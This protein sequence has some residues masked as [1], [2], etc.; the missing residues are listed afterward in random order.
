LVYLLLL[1]ALFSVFQPLASLMRNHREVRY[2]ITP[3]NLVWSAGAV[4][5][6]DAASTFAPPS[7]FH[8]TCSTPASVN[9]AARTWSAVAPMRE[10]RT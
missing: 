10:D 9:Q 6:A 5:A 7:I 2:L 1:A 3:A 4:I 8:F